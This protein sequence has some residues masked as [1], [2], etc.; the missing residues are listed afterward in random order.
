MDT[1]HNLAPAAANAQTEVSTINATTTYS[2]TVTN[3]GGTVVQIM[4]YLM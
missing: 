3:S 2:V 4:M 1:N